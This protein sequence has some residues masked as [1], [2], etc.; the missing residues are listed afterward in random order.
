MMR[1]PEACSRSES[2]SG[3]CPPYWTTHD[4]SPPP[5]SS[6]AMIAE[7]SSNVSGSK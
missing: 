1:I 6:R 3:V 4:T 2:L 5:C 7:T